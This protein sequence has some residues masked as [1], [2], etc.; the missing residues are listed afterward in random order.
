MLYLNPRLALS[1]YPDD[2][3]AAVPPRTRGELRL[4]VALAI[5]DVAESI[6]N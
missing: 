5:R 4:G 1:D 3:K 6:G 2:V